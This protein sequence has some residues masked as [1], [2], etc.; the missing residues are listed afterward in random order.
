MAHR[1]LNGR[2]VVNGAVAATQNGDAGVRAH[3]D[4]EF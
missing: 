3:A 1:S 2:W 4:Y